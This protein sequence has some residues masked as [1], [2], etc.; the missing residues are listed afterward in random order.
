MP[1]AMR[2]PNGMPSSLVEAKEDAFERLRTMRPDFV[3][4][5]AEGLYGVSREA[6]MPAILELL[7][8]PYLGSDPLTLA[9]CLDKA[10][11]KEILAY[12][13]SRRLRLS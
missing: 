13:G 6:Q 11:T 9:L 5:I 4:N 12:H 10:R 1:S 7:Q 2:L 8:F 3:F